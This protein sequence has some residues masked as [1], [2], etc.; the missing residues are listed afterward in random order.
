[1]HCGRINITFGDGP[2]APKLTMLFHSFISQVLRQFFVA[3][4]L[5][6]TGTRQVLELELFLI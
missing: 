5:R 3:S 6:V 2:V 1:M 4:M